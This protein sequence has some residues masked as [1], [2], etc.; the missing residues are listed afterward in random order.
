MTAIVGL[1]HEDRVYIGGDSAG[2]SGYDITVRADAKVFHN[3]PYLFGFTSSFRMGQLLRYALTPPIVNSTD[4]DR[5]MVTTFMD[6]VR[7]CLK[8]GG[9]A[10]KE[11]EGETGGRFLVG[12]NSQLY[13]I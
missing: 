3:G 8:T 5:F 4:L 6:A 7:E 10:R 12:I 1:V 13:M 11:S 9:W 2:V